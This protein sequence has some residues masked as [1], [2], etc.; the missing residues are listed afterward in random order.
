MHSRSRLQ[1]NI[2]RNSF[3]ILTYLTWCIPLNCQAFLLAASKMKQRYRRIFLNNLSYISISLH[4]QLIFQ[5]PTINKHSI[6]WFIIIIS[7]SR[8]KKKESRLRRLNSFNF[9]WNWLISLFVKKERKKDHWK[10]LRERKRSE[11]E[12]KKALLENVR[13]RERRGG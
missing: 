11:L 5:F 2:L 12:K 6:L 3:E 10:I 7:I 13:I 4:H 8:K 1:D 9:S